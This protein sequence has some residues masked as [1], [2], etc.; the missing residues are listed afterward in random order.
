MNIGKYNI[1]AV[2]TGNFYL[3]GGAMFG[4]I[5][6]PIW[7]KS[8]PS[9]ERNRVKLSAR[10]LLLSNEK[11]KILIDTG[12]GNKWDDK[13][14]SIYSFDYQF[15]TLEKSLLK[16]GISPDEITDVILTHLHF[17]HAGGSTKFENDRLVPSFPN[18]IYYVQKSNF[19]WAKTPTEKDRASFIKENFQPLYDYG[20]L[21]FIDGNEQFDDEIELKKLDGHT[22][23][24]QLIKISDSS[25][26]LFYCGDLFPYTAHIHIPALPGFDLQPLVTLQE[27]KKILQQAIEEE[28]K[29]FFEH[30]PDT[31]TTKVQKTEKGFR[32]KEQM[33]SV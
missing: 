24:Q 21:K 6:K 9:D 17:D 8:N 22:F 12:C 1:Q 28:W 18:A 23:G 5:P 29:L 33:N 7:E 30:D 31:I 2:E 25:Q 16:S 11:R 10:C 32:A 26:T 27:K 13:A 19:E 3:D 4:V 14:K 15:N 20:I